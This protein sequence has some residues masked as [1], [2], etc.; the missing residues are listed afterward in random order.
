M[1]NVTMVQTTVILMHNVPTPREILLAIVVKVL[2]ETE[3]LVQ[4][5]GM[6]VEFSDVVSLKL[7]LL[8]SDI[9]TRI[10]HYII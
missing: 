10:V 2:L 1:T 8:P 9:T 4:V 7:I 6:F 3:N 5:G